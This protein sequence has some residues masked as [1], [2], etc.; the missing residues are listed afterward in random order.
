MLARANFLTDGQL[1]SSCW[2]IISF[3]LNLVKNYYIN[4]LR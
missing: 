2:L 1:F 4:Y 3:D